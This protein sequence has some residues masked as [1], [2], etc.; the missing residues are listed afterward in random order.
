MTVAVTFTTEHGVEPK[1]TDGRNVLGAA[2]NEA[3]LSVTI[4]PAGPEVGEKE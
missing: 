3:P 1:L 4:V 2:R